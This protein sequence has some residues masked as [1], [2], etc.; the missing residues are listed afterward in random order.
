MG[1]KMR[2]KDNA[3]GIWL[4]PKNSKS[5]AR[6]FSADDVSHIRLSNKFIV[7]EVDQQSQG[8]LKHE[9]MKVKSPTGKSESQKKKVLLLGSSHG[10]DIG[11]MLQNHLGTEYEVTSIFKPNKLLENVI[12]DLANLGKDLTK[13]DHIVIVGGPGNSLE[14]NYHYSK[15]YLYQLM[16]LFSSYIKIT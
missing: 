14:R 7:L 10:R 12:E 11:P 13:E 9:D 5:R 8:L 16:H 4:K 2:D 15:F 1:N 6:R 3:N